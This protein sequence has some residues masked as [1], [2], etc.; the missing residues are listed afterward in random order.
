MKNSDHSV[1]NAV[2]AS[3]RVLRAVEM[4]ALTELTVIPAT[5][6]FSRFEQSSNLLSE[7]GQAPEFELNRKMQAFL[8]KHPAAAGTGKINSVTRNALK[9]RGYLK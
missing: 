4:F 6:A 9:F 7:M 8:Q 1:K 2:S 3:I 5:Y